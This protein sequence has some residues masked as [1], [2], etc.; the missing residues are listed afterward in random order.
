M[1]K[2]ILYCGVG[3]ATNIGNAFLD[4]GLWGVFKRVAPNYN[5][6]TTSN[7]PYWVYNR[8]FN[9]F[10]FV[11]PERF[12]VKNNPFDLRNEFETD[13]YC[14]SGAFLTKELI[15]F[16]KK[17]IENL[18]KTQSKVMLLGIGGGNDYSKKQISYIQSVLKELNLVALV[19]RDEETYA[20]FNDYAKASYNGIDNAFFMPDYFKPASLKNKGGFDVFTFD[21]VKEPK[22]VTSKKILRL[23]HDLWQA[24]RIKHAIKYKK[25]IVRHN[26][27]MSDWLDDY[28]NIYANCNTTYSDRVHACVATLIYGNKAKYFGKSP[29]SL[30][31]ERINLSN[32]KDEVVSLNMK[33][34]EKEKQKEIDFLQEFFR[35]EQ[36]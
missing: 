15:G 17:F 11:M 30:L 5:I 18:I 36:K 19:S 8:Y 20:N 7:M 29:R 12:K 27:M 14:L 3:S 22:I 2:S 33:Y 23:Q 31:F 1:S 10:K 16:N 6:I 34:I 4:Y 28:L 24:G 35:E 13:Y 9:L 25:N 26:D 21:D 32:I